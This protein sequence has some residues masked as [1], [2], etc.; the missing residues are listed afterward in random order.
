MTAAVLNRSLALLV[1]GVLVTG[2]AQWRVGTPPGAWIVTLHSLLAGVLAVAVV[3]KVRRS[4]PRAIAGRRRRSLALATLLSVLV[5]GALGLGWAWA[6]SDGHPA[7][8]GFTILVL[9]AWLGFAILPLLTLHLLPRRWR[10]LRLPQWGA[11]TGPRLTRRAALAGGGLALVGLMTSATVLLL[12]RVGGDSRRFTGSRFLPDRAIPPATTFLGEPV[13]DVDPA[14]WRLAVRGVVD[15][16]LTLSMAQLRSLGEETREAIL[17]CTSG[18]AVRTS[19]SGVGLAR[20][21]DVVGVRPEATRVIVRAVSGWTADFPLVEARGCLLATGVAG[22]ALPL[23]NG[24][25]CR[26]VAPERRGLDWVKW[27]VD[28]EVA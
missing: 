26:L 10:L 21:F 6:V 11:T 15:R 12:A 22:Q 16:P 25:P 1:A 18:W 13:P 7:V 3:V 23:G 2:V 17:D 8:R 27:V 20:L 4:V 9:H 14:A 5:A 24:A 28:I 19:W